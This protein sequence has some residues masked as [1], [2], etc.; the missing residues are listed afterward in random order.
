MGR[1]FRRRHTSEADDQ[2]SY[3]SRSNADENTNV[4]GNVD[5]NRD[6]DLYANQG[7]FDNPNTHTDGHATAKSYR[8]I[9]T[10][11]RNDNVPNYRE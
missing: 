10:C 3:I 2:L 4:D 5:A 6:N 9:D 8:N 11:F 7:T 1:L